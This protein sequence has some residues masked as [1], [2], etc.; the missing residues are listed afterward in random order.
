[1]RA[2]TSLYI[3]LLGKLACLSPSKVEVNVLGPGACKHLSEHVRMC[4]DMCMHLGGRQV[5]NRVSRRVYSHGHR[6]V[7][8]YVYRWVD[9][10]VHNEWTLH[11]PQPCVTSSHILDPQA[12]ASLNVHALALLGCMH[13]VGALWLH[14]SSAPIDHLGFPFA[15]LSHLHSSAFTRVETRCR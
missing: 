9:R 13:S 14:A 11:P 6:H 8:K 5:Q 1:M 7:Y 12:L 15:R 3:L 10:H 2:G 4:M